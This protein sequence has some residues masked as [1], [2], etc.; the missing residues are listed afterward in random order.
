MEGMRSCSTGRTS[1]S[2]ER[3]VGPVRTPVPSSAA[4]RMNDLMS[5]DMTIERM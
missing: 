2:L 4:K 3:I 5:E 1:M